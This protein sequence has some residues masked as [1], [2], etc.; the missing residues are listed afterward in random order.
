M[1]LAC[2]RDNFPI[3][4]FDHSLPSLVTFKGTLMP[5]L[6]QRHAHVLTEGMI[7]RS[8]VKSVPDLLVKML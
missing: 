1:T 6:L 7:I 8:N 2:K 4:F 3:C 5:Y